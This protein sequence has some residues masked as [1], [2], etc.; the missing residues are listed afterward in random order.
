MNKNSANNKKE[1]YE[2]SWVSSRSIINRSVVYISG[3]LREQASG[4]LFVDVY[5]E[6][7]LIEI[8]EQRIFSRN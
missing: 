3:S 1:I 6:F 4:Q 8:L 7:D 2:S 5:T